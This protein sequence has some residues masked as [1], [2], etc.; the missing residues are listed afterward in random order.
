M[1]R[2]RSVYEVVELPND[3]IAL[4]RIDGGNSTATP[5]Q[6]SDG[7]GDE[8]GPLTESSDD[9]SSDEAGLLASGSAETSLTDLYQV[10][11]VLHFCS[12]ADSLR[13]WP[14]FR[15]LGMN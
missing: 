9:A 1:Q 10:S 8:I 2:E 3:R 12:L 7:S 5:D 15:V 13:N 6:S 14:K 4:V 11:I